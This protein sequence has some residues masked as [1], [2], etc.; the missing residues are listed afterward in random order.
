MIAFCL[1]LPAAPLRAEDAG[2]LTRALQT[3]STGDWVAAQRQAADSGSLAN[4]LISWQR[5]RAGQGPFGEYLD[6]AS[7]NPDWPG[8]PL[9]FQ[10][11][12]A[13]ITPETDKHQVIGLFKLHEAQTGR[14]AL[15]L[16]AA[17]PKRDAKKQAALIWA[18]AKIP[19]SEAEEVFF[20]E[21]YGDWLDEKT[22]ESRVQN[23]LDRGL[24]AEARRVIPLTGKRRAALFEARAMVQAGEAGMDAAI[25]ALPDALRDDAGLA[26][27]RFR[28]RVRAKLGQ[29]ARAL[30]L[31]RSTSPEALR[32][33]S[34]WAGLRAD[35]ARAALRDG[36]TDLAYR[37][38]SGHHL[39]KEDRNW[40][41]LV[42]LTGYAALKS[43]KL[44]EARA[45]FDLLAQESR[46]SI[47]RSRGLY[48]ASRAAK[49]AD[50]P[51]A[52]D[53]LMQEAAGFQTSYYGQLASEAAGIPMDA[54]L[55]HPDRNP[56]RLPQWRDSDMLKDPRVQAVIWLHVAG[57][58]DL[59]ARFALHIAE[60]ASPEDIGRLSRLMLELDQT[61]V[62]LRLA[63]A[64]ASQGVTYPEALFP[65]P[66]LEHP[67]FDIPYE[68]VLAIS[69]QESE[70]NPRAGS[71][72]GARG[73]MQLMPATAQDIARQTGIRYDLDAISSDAAVNA[74][75]GAYYLRQLRDRFG[76][77]LALIAAGYNA[78]PGRA[79]QWTRQLGEIRSEL[80]PVDWVESIPFDET[81]NYVMRVGE[82]LTIYRARLAGK[83][84]PFTLKHDLS[85]GAQL[86]PKAGP[87]QTI[88]FT[89]DRATQPRAKIMPPFIMPR[90]LSEFPE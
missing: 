2:L 56:G 41:D 30:M 67:G 11:A 6:F 90:P 35:Y 87:R 8:M 83:P 74:F 51:E 70:F 73:L 27:D 48:W 78:G 64:A 38:A 3:A 47:T 33:P 46:S 45:A 28:F 13:T 86:P 25:L 53:K 81:R 44:P 84:V 88:P 23:L 36:D 55:T 22:H 75:Y 4:D 59:S 61:H 85:G 7:R 21:E 1:G 49:S 65:L 37:F 62:A 66:R 29:E 39:Q 69:R 32:D 31:E 77:S 5:L 16:I 34:A 43:G 54:A 50:D 14:G 26:L 57:N 68:L 9:L 15:A 89:L 72:V 63:K 20:I 58:T 40:A 82:A 24:W 60:T 76:P 18:D 80:D 19:F 12:E 71:H 10:R 52:A 17:L 42:F 79:N